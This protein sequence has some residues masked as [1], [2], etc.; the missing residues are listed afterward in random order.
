MSS[1]IGSVPFATLDRS[2][3]ILPFS[4]ARCYKLNATDEEEE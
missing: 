2:A 3:L 1:H 4:F